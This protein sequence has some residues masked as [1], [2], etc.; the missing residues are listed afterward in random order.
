M[1]LLTFLYVFIFVLDFVGPDCNISCVDDQ[2]IF[3]DPNDGT[4]DRYPVEPV[5]ECVE[6]DGSGNYTAWF[7]YINNNTN[8]IYLS[9][10]GENVIVGANFSVSV[11]K[12]EAKR[13]TYFFSI[14]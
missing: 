3:V 11:T 2:G 13:V 12:F 5:F 6:L 4:D 8:N 10:T 7:G 9:G 14:R 1:N